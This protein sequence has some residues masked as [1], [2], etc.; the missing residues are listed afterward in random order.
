MKQLVNKVISS[1]TNFYFI[2]KVQLTF[3]FNGISDSMETEKKMVQLRDGDLG[4][5]FIPGIT[6]DIYRAVFW[7][8]FFALTVIFGGISTGIA[9]TVI[10]MGACAPMVSILK[11]YFTIKHMHHLE[12][13]D[14]IE[15]V[16]LRV[17]CH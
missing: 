13:E 11:A 4:Y 7:T 12:R 1:L 9:L 17:N 6:G 10:C 2:I 16:L 8:G 3:I 14:E 15:S 5:F